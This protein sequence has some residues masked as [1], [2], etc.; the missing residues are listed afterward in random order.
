MANQ[1]CSIYTLLGEFQSD[2]SRNNDGV[3]KIIADLEFISSIKDGEKINVESRQIQQNNILTS[4]LRMMGRDSRDDTFKFFLSTVTRAFELIDMICKK[5][6]LICRDIIIGVQNAKQGI[7]ETVMTYKDDRNIGCKLNT[8]VKF[9][10]TKIEDLRKTTP[11]L[12]DDVDKKLEFIDQTTS[13]K[14]SSVLI[15]ES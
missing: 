11:E 14:S 13:T 5:Q 10:R 12:F 3:Y 7:L 9:I 2:L 8:L 1:I 15:N 6:I 4:I